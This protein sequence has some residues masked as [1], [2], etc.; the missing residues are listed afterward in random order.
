MAVTNEARAH[1]AVSISTEANVSN[2]NNRNTDG[3]NPSTD[4]KPKKKKRYAKPKAMQDFKVVVLP[5]RVVPPD[6]AAK[7]REE[8]FTIMLEGLNDPRY[9]VGK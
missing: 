8:L 2:N 9:L 7:L 6:E 1:A 4:Q 5:P 3:G